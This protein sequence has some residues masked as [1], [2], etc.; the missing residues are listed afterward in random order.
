MTSPQFPRRPESKPNPFA[1]GPNPFAD[2]VSPAESP[3]APSSPAQSSPGKNNVYATQMQ[4]SVQPYRPV[5]YEQ[6][7]PDRSSLVLR[8][9]I[10]GA[11]LTG[12]NLIVA[13]LL[14]FSGD[15]F[16][17]MVYCVPMGSFG[18]ASAIPA[19]HMAR[20]DMRAIRAG[21]MDRRGEFRTRVA[22]WLGS[23]ATM[24]GVSPVLVGFA[25]TFHAMFS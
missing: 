24:A 16:S 4:S 18:L 14:A 19:W 21:A 8:F 13:A 9:G 1:S 2:S 25:S 10:F 6:S 15:W 7:L 11:S 3:P 20:A 23:V 22:W 12:L 5:E 17:M